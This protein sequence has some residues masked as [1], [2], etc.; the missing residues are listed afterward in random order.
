[1]EKLLLVLKKFSNL[2]KL[3]FIIGKDN[4]IDTNSLILL[5]KYF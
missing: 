1:M 2:K 5:G 3:Q 4:G